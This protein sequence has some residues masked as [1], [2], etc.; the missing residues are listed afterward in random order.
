[1]VTFIIYFQLVPNVSVYD[2]VVDFPERDNPTEIRHYSN[3]IF[4]CGT[5]PQ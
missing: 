2:F 3:L 5:L 1:M 4:L